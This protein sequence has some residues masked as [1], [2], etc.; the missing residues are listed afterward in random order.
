MSDRSDAEDDPFRTVVEYEK[1]ILQLTDEIE[2]VLDEELNNHP[3]TASQEVVISSMSNILQRNISNKQ[4]ARGV[5]RA[6]Y[7]YLINQSEDFHQRLKNYNASE[8]LIDWLA[9]LN[10]KF[11]LQAMDVYLTEAQGGDYFL[12]I[13]SD[14]V[15]R[16]PYNTTGLNHRI[17]VG[18]NKEY[19]I[20]VD[21]Q[22]NLRLIN[23]LLREQIRIS[24]TFGES[25]TARMNE[26]TI[27]EI[28]SRVSKLNE[29][30]NRLE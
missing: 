8:D 3:S 13:D 19:E 20:S 15:I 22:S 7:E 2:Q 29:T 12:E 28:A 26:D 18:Y 9:M 6:L 25:A 23:Q 24:E 21:P 30:I 1:Q 27:E 4:D 16:S 5:S 10:S 11:M 14:L 17:R